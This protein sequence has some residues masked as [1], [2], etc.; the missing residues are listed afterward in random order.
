MRSI[1]FRTI[2]L[3]IF[4]SIGMSSVQA[5]IKIG[6]VNMTNVFDAYY[7]TK[8]AETQIKEQRAEADKIYKGMLEDYKKANEE[9]KS[10][11]DGSNDQAISAEE[12]AKR[13]S[14]AEKKLLDLQEIEKSVKQYEAQARTSLNA[15]ERRMRDKIVD[16]IREKV[17]LVSSSGG[18]NFVFDLAAVTPYN[19]PIVLYTDGKNDLTQA[20]IKELNATAP[21]GAL[22]ESTGTK[23]GAQR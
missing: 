3:A 16:E 21:A 11:L 20:V 14:A 1:L 7:R 4:M 8:L 19:T 15:M 17:N 10:L 13:K 22:G 9:Y 6:M 2:I 12:R 23:S 5:Q 18:F